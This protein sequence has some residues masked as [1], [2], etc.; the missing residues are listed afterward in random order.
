MDEAADALENAAATAL[1]RILQ[2]ALTNVAK[3]AAARRVHVRLLR[4]NGD[5]C[6]EVRDDGRGLRPGDIADP[7]RLGLLGMKERADAFGGSI[8]VSAL[9][10]VGTT[11]SV[12]LPV[13]NF[14]AMR[15][16]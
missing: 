3:H 4:K 2:E 11:V 8:Q 12:R 16:A 10:N 6:L 5:V 15:I 9:P 1:F 14:G 7:S 13:A